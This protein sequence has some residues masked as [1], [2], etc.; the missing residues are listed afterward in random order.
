M[1]TYVHATVE[2]GGYNQAAACSVPEDARVGLSR[3]QLQCMIHPCQ[4]GIGG[5]E[6]V[7]LTADHRLD[8]ANKIDHGVVLLDVIYGPRDRCPCIVFHM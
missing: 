1:A 4:C 7:K 5:E 3:T 2:V 8:I 6:I